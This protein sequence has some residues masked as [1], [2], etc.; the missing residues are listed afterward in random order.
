[1]YTRQPGVGQ[2]LDALAI[3]PFHRH[4]LALIAG[5]MFF[6]AFDNY[7]SGGVLG[8]LVN[9]GISDI[10]LNALFISIGFVGLTI[11]A[12]MA[13]ILGDR[14]GR[15]FSYQFN[16]MVFGLG[17]IAAALSPSM[18]WLVFFRFVMG[19]GLGAE[20]V[21]GYSTLIEFIPARSRGR[22]AAILNLI[23]NLSL[24]LSAM[25][26][27]VV[28]PHFGWRWM[29]VIPGIGALVVWY[30]RKTLPESPRWL[31]S[32]GRTEEANAIVRD[33]ESRS[34]RAGEPELIAQAG[35]DRGH[36]GE[37]FARGQLSRTIV[38][39]AVVVIGF[40]VMYAFVSWVPTLLVK[41]GFDISHSLLMTSVMFA[42]GP[43]G[44]LIS[45]A[46]ADRLGRKWGLVLFSVLG[47]VFGMVYPFATSM[48]SIAAFG[49]A[50]T[51]CIYVLSALGLATYT[52]ELFP[53]RLR[54]R[55]M[56]LCNA[57]GRLANVGVPYAVVAVF[58]IAGLLGVVC[59]MAGMFVLLA[60]VLLVLGVETRL[61]S[62][63]EVH[64]EMPVPGD[65]PAEATFP[66][67]RVTR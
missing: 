24:F 54:L 66:T 21:V 52:P 26:S 23:T 40:S 42:G 62:L 65:A 1:M 10:H 35:P 49:F 30:L 59:F 8:A 16:L 3:G 34:V 33:I 58:S 37:L 20:I 25:A 5:G 12:W 47:A 64:A 55:G 61:R 31:A 22:Y 57:L 19:L 51:V 44:S 36:L 32:V 38:G 14:F 46:I 29:F 27:Y 7:L 50:V 45:F 48:A 15:R 39:I 17:S 43:V 56:G 60:I 4:L 2:R 53:T 63:E 6:D 18:G 41:R 28:I 9:A 67:T 11:G 13:G